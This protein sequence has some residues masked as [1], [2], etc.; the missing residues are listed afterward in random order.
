MLW[1]LFGM[2]YELKMNCWVRVGVGGTL[3]TEFCMLRFFG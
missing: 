3:K 1:V 2:N